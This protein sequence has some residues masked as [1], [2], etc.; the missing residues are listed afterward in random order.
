MRSGVD[1]KKF[2]QGLCTNDLTKL[3]EP[4]ACMPASFLTS[5]GRIFANSLLYLKENNVHNGASTILI[6]LPLP[7]SSVND[8]QKYLTMYK[9]RSKV[10][11]KPAQ[12]QCTFT[13]TALCSTN[14]SDLEKYPNAVLMV[15]DPRIEGFGSRVLQSLPP[16]LLN[17]QPQHKLSIITAQI[18]LITEN[19]NFEN[20]QQDVEWYDRYKLV[21]GFA[22]GPEV[23]NKIPLECNLDLLHYISFAKGCY[24][25]QELTARTKFKVSFLFPPVSLHFI[26]HF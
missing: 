21:H 6:E 10:T 8:V 25:G 11:I 20:D 5:K 23:G 24:I 15:K 9:L 1:A 13:T 26:L 14:S 7:Q 22:E 12:V 19:N 4:G 3:V 16:G 17:S 2:V 18:S